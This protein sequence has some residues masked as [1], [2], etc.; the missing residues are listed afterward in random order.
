MSVCVC[1]VSASKE[2]RK[3]TLQLES[4]DTGESF[5]SDHMMVDFVGPGQGRAKA[6][7][8]SED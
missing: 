7:P 3:R 6:F 4:P 1:V 5:A 8:Q 2:G